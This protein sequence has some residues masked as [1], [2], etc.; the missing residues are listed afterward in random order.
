MGIEIHNSQNKVVFNSSSLV[1]FI[2][3]N[4]GFFFQISHDAT[5]SSY[6]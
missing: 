4:S 5:I 6:V 1:L 2:T 3:E